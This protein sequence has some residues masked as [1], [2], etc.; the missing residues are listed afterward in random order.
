MDYPRGSVN[1]LRS[2]GESAIRHIGPCHITAGS[3][4]ARAALRR[5]GPASRRGW[6]AGLL[7]YIVKRS[8][9][10]AAASW[11]VNHFKAGWD[12]IFSTNADEFRR[13]VADKVN[14]MKVSPIRQSS[15]IALLNGRSTSSLAVGPSGSTSQGSS[16]NGR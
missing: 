4:A 3:P 7:L 15:Y 12:A 14:S 8:N 6:Q 13:N 1:S 11:S 5:V 9:G 2:N 10:E 16:S